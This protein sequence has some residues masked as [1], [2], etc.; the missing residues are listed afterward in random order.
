MIILPFENKTGWSKKATILENWQFQ[1]IQIQ[2]VLPVYV[3]G[4]PAFKSQLICS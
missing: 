3:R 2:G 1:S 4:K